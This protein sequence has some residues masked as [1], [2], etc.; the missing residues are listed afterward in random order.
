MSEPSWPDEMHCSVEVYPD[1]G[2]GMP[3]VERS[4]CRV[5]VRSAASGR[6]NSSTEVESVKDEAGTRWMSGLEIEVCSWL[7]AL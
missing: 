2:V 1:Y 6:K 4:F 5:K 7:V 3:V